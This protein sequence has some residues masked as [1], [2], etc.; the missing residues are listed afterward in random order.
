M[1]RVEINMR[2]ADES[3]YGWAYIEPYLSKQGEKKRPVYQALEQIFREHEMYKAMLDNL[4]SMHK[5]LSNQLEKIQKEVHFTLLR[6][7][8]AEKSARTLLHLWNSYNFDNDVTNYLPMS[9]LVTP[10]I[11]KAMNEVGKYYKELAA[12]KR[13]RSESLLMNSDDFTL[14]NTEKILQ[15]KESINLSDGN[16][17][18]ETFSDWIS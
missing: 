4:S 2:E 12:K 10:P 14:P 8:D 17:V 7:G 15:E 16:E 6:S 11:E 9:E 5:D 3:D 13:S 1:R 18:Q